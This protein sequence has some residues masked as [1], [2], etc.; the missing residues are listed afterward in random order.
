LPFPPDPLIWYCPG[1]AKDYSPP[2]PSILLYIHV[3]FC[4]AK[5]RYCAF[6]SAP[7][8]G[9]DLQIFVENLKTEMT[10]WGERLEKPK[11]A[12]VFFGGGTPSLLPPG[13]LMGIKDRL[14]RSFTLPESFEFTFEANPDSV[15]TKEYLSALLRLGVNRLSLGFQSLDDESLRLLGRPHTSQQALQ[16]YMLARDLGFRNIS[17]DLIWGLPGQR[18]TTWIKELK[19]VTDLRP[20]HL[21]CYN[22]TVEPD[23]PLEEMVRSG[24]V[25][26]PTEKDQSNMF[27]YGADFLESVGY[28]QYEISNFSRLGLHSRHNM[29]YWEGRDY[30][31]LGPSAVS[32]LNGRRWR[33]PPNLAQWAR[34]VNRK[35]LDKDAEELTPDIR[36]KELIMLRL[37]TSGGLKLKAYRSLTGKNFMKTHASIL[38]TLRQHDLIRVG[39]DGVRLSRTGMLVSD[40]I[41]QRLFEGEGLAG[42]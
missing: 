16:T 42:C 29:G 32:T 34:A 41:L 35:E 40:T 24:Q 33:N 38:K 31:G 28:F 2:T 9:A 13:A 39:R 18:Q 36:L 14:E 30:L 17:L 27:I 11:L 21:S 3:P 6:H 37:R 1:M 23:T 5:C 7:M 25:K 26:L 4:S 22:L 10:I 15:G 12:T 20:E 19:A 8:R